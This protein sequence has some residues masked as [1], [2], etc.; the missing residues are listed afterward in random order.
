MQIVND[1]QTFLHYLQNQRKHFVVYF[2]EKVYL[3]L[4]TL[5]VWTKEIFFDFRS[6]KGV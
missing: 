2:V 1:F 6:K 3:N 5:V 4:I